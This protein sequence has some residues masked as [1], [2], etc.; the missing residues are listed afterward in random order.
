MFFNPVFH[1]VKIYMIS[2]D[3][4]KFMHKMYVQENHDRLNL[5]RSAS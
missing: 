1:K 2:F 3:E 5:Q 4:K